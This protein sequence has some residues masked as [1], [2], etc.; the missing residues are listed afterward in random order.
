MTDSVATAD[1]TAGVFHAMSRVAR[2][3]WRLPLLPPH[4]VDLVAG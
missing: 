2:R 4:S 1:A 3:G